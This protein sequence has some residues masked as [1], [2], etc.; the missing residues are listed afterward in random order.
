MLVGLIVILS[1]IFVPI[2]NK[3]RNKKQVDAVKKNINVTAEPSKSPEIKNEVTEEGVEVSQEAATISPEEEKRQKREALLQENNCI[4]IIIIEKIGVELA[5]EEGDDDETL[6]RA[7]GHMPSSAAIGEKGNCVIS[8]H[9]GGFYGEFFLNV[10]KLEKEDIIQLVSKDGS[11]HNYA[12]YERK[13]VKR[14]DWSVVDALNE[15]ETL[16]LIT[17]VDSSQEERIIVSAIAF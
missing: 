7:V 15:Q 10:D 2:I 17:C 8:A 4:G 11:V 5:I 12:V 14:T 1:V 13:V 6:K 9:H 16:T 3:N